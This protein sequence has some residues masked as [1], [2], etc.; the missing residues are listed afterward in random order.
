MRAS[1]YSQY[2]ILPI[3]KDTLVIIY[4]YHVNQNKRN[5]DPPFILVF[6]AMFSPWLPPLL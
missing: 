2:M 6:N 3:P 1:F 4:I 5:K